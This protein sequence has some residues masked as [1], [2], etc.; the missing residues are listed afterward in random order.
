MNSG[1]CRSRMTARRRRNPRIDGGADPYSPQ[2]YTGGRAALPVAVT[3]PQFNASWN[4]TS[5]SGS[6]A[7]DIASRAVC[8]LHDDRR[9]RYDIDM[10]NERERQCSTTHRR[11]HSSM[12]PQQHAVLCRRTL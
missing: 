12:C 11:A 8:H 3:A 7:A 6:R 4:L 2:L 1:V 10:L 5:L 9:E